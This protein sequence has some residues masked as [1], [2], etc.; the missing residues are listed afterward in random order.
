MQGT[1]DA[2][3]QPKS[4]NLV[5]AVVT[6]LLTALALS[7]GDALIKLVSTD[8]VLWQIFVIR[9]V[10]AIPALVIIIRLRSMTT[11]L[12]PRRLGWTALRS[13]MLTS[14]WVAYYAALPHVALA[15]AAAAFY[16]LPIFI[17]LFAAL[18]IG[19]RV[20]PAGWLSV[21]LGFVGVLLILKPQAGD[22][23]QYA[24]LP[25]IS[26]I[27]Y[28]LAM[29]LTRTKCRD[30]SPLV[31][32]LC[33]N[34]SFVVVGLAATVLTMLIDTPGDAEPGTSFLLGQ[35]TAMGRAEWLSMC[36][37]ATAVIIG[38]VGAAI[39]YQ[40]GPP[41][42]VATFDFTYVAFAAAWGLLFFGEV[43]GT[44]KLAGMAM[45]VAAGILAIRQ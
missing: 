17:A 15:V 43:P 26:A 25:L 41:A 37:L 14:M 31:L 34:V 21:L 40:A 5:L 13:V 6:I 36:L 38:S 27:L 10:I 44:I 39:A 3:S 9:S 24:L 19:D 18:F 33:L 35:W 1:S 8:I 23:N 28:A 29:I 4:D 11:S 16:T 7:L 42:I 30:E 22:F 12:I 20:G 2:R 32:S 45:V